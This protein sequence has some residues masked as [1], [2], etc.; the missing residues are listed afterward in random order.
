MVAHKPTSGPRRLRSVL[1]H[2]FR[3]K[4]FIAGS[5]N[6]HRLLDNCRGP[7]SGVGSRLMGS[8]D[9]TLGGLRI[10]LRKTSSLQT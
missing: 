9:C 6:A 7:G 4:P 1:A 5:V 10:R 3:L 8:M 2:P